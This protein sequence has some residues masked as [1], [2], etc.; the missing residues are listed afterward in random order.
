M[1]FAKCAMLSRVQCVQVIMTIYMGYL[2]NYFYLFVNVSFV[3]HLF[4]WNIIMY[5]SIKFCLWSAKL[6]WNI[7]LTNWLH[8]VQNREKSILRHPKPNINTS[9][10][11]MPLQSPSG[12]QQL[13][14]LKRYIDGGTFCCFCGKP[15][16]EWICSLQ[17]CFE[18]N[19]FKL[20]YFSSTLMYIF[21]AEV[22]KELISW[23][24]QANFF[25]TMLCWCISVQNNCVRKELLWR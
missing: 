22:S 11:I 18:G 1:T 25:C 12:L 7:S 23:S 3:F 2:E 19:G 24:I 17:L 5:S 8:I 10:A 4:H 15:S 16:K 21:V 14:S 6:F 20:V 13:Y 9:T